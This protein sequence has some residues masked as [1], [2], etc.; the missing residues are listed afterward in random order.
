ML[1]IHGLIRPPDALPLQD[2]E[3]SQLVRNSTIHTYTNHTAAS[4]YKLI[5]KAAAK[6]IRDW[7]GMAGLLPLT[8]N[9][10][11]CRVCTAVE[12]LKLKSKRNVEKQEY[13]C[14]LYTSDA[15]DEEDSVD[16]GGR[17]IIKKK[18]HMRK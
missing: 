5:P 3:D 13:L 11:M 7:A 8:S 14:L 16:L 10:G 2:L 4:Q 6:A 15:A 12:V 9:N 1:C 17:R 18:K